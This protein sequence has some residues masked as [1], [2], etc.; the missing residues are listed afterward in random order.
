MSIFRLSATFLLLS[1]I[2]SLTYQVTWVRLLGL[3]MGSTSASIST[4][5]A[6]FFLGLALGSYLA[7]RITRNRIDNLRAYI[8]LELLIGISGIILLPVLL[9]LDSVMALMPFLGTHL[10]FK[11]IVAIT[12]LIIPTLCMGATF[13]V[14]ASILIRNQS[15][16]GL[17]MSQLYSL[18]TAGAVLGAALSGFVFIPYWG[19]DGAIYIA[20]ALNASIVLAAL[21]FNRRLTLPPITIPQ[22]ASGGAKIHHDDDHSPLRIQALVVLFFTGFVAIATE[23]GWTKF[24]VIFAGT[25]IYGFAAILT[26]FLVGIAAGSW[27]VK[28][29]LENLPSPQ[30]WMAVGLVSLGGSLLLTRAGLS[31]VPTVYEAINYLQ[32]PAFVVHTV[33]Y[34]FIFVLLFL[35]TFLFGALFPLNLKLYCGGLTGVRSRIGKAY[36]VNT[37]A[38]ILG[39]IAAGFWLIPVYGT[40][41]LLTSMAVIILTLPI[42]FLPS[43]EAATLRVAIAVLMFISIGSN[44]VLPHLNYEKLI[45]SVDYLYDADARNGKKPTFL[46]LKEGKAGVI[47]VVTY[48][49]KIAKVQNNGLNESLVN[50]KDPHKTLVVENMLG[51]IPYLLHENAKSA[52]IVGYGGGITT[53]ALT[54]TNLKSIQVVE[55]EPAVVEAGRAIYGGDI[56]ALKDPRVKVE[57]N[58]ARNTLLLG[59]QTYD[60]VVAQPSHPW[61]AGAANVFTKQ[62]FQIAK[63]KLNSGGIY[64][65]WVNLFNMDVTTLRAIFKAFLDVFPEGVSFA[66]LDTGDFLLFG[67]D[68]ALVFDYNRMNERM[69]QPDIKEIFANNGIYNAEQLLWYFGLSRQEIIQAAGNAQPNTDTNI[70]SEVRLSAL[71]QQPSGQQDPYAFLRK[72]YHFDVGHYFA[73]NVAAENIYNAGLCFLNWDEPAVAQKAAN[74]LQGIDSLRARSLDYQIKWSGYEYGKA[75]E[76]YRQHKE[77]LDEVHVKQTEVFAELGQLDEAQK[78]IAQIK[79]SVQRRVAIAALLYK[80][81]QWNTLAALDPQSD[82]ERQWQ[83]VGL[84]KSNLQ[85][86]GA[87]LSSLMSVESE[88]IPQLEVLVR[89]YAVKQSTQQMGKY[90]RQLFKVIDKLSERLTKLVDKA[91]A[92]NEIVR[93]QLILRKIE[94]I[95][96]DAGTLPDLKKRLSELAVTGVSLAA[97]SK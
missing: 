71:V 67:S 39:S 66:N 74:L 53:R 32:A 1:G 68:K 51:L 31:I 57:F 88:E 81:G 33:K 26:I 78:S 18:N 85:S 60:I 56:P 47:S 15:E 69:N 95:N 41:V 36:A 5:L 72:T 61:R 87:Q 28:S 92:N 96:P 22:T 86:A 21:Y 16:M 2:A 73:K 76:L 52:F 42:L 97:T 46:Y 90:A 94:T 84:S 80:K 70:L 12:L 49:N 19:L 75:T 64:G 43:L 50:M 58:D 23:V 29:R 45:A 13:P 8:L 6:A 77:W 3:S 55:L 9:N 11:F 17:R 63:S 14:M 59:N 4:V 89:Y 79:D 40:D 38:S 10:V 30:L 20:F 83:L 93:A 27:V 82:K 65:Q 7:E 25:T 62:F 44:W 91:I 24:L 54:Y 34:S 35:P 37:L 48:D